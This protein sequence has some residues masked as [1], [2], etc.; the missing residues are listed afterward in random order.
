M[1]VNKQA[2]TVSGGR[3]V[4][5]VWVDSGAVRGEGGP[6]RPQLVMPVTIEMNPQPH[7]AMLGVI[8]M[9]ARLGSQQYAS[10]SQ[11]L[12]QPVRQPLFSNGPAHSVPN[13]TAEQRAEV[14]F[15][16]SPA[17]VEDVERRRL[18]TN[19]ELF[20]VYL[21]LDLIVAAVKSYNEFGSGQP[22]EQTPWQPELGIFYQAMP[23]WNSHVEP[24]MVHIEQ[25]VWVRNVL[26]GLGYDRL[27][28]IELL[29]P[30]PLPD[31]RS[32]TAQFDKARRALNEG[33][34]DDCI[35][36]CR[37][38][39]TMWRQQHG[40]T[41]SMPVA[42]MVAQRRGWPSTDV[43]RTLLDSLWKE[44]GDMASYPHHPEGQVDAQSFTPKDAR[45]VLLLTAALCD[46]VSE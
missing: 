2:I 16:L 42:T 45:L 34:S 40:A 22:A 41:R 29:F 11:L 3:L 46:Y 19:S 8:W 39:L 9:E 6:V 37:G 7:G 44:V 12:C 24:V 10:P 28:L 25:S 31:H 32:A 23:F 15:F 14:R 13:G 43:R 38:L 20:T 33:R 27:R 18:T 26:P 1:Q 35:K 36:E 5:Q 17:E 4:G 30:P 21:S